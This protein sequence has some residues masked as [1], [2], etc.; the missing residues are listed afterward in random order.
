VGS[1]TGD[2]EIW[3]KVALEVECLSVG[4]LWREPGGRVL[5]LGILNDISKRLW[6]WASLL[7]GAPFWGIWR[8]GHLPGI[9]RVG[10]GGSEDGAS[11]SQEAL[12]RGPQGSSFT[13]DPGR[14]AREVSRYGHLSPWGPLSVGG[15]WY[16]RGRLVYRG[17]W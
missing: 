12:W 3:L 17:L 2:F 5:L 7:T 4:A 11:L 14:Y 6:K 13:R 8:R 1:S 16:V 15:T 9:L 10:R